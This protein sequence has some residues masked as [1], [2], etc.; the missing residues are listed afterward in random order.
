MKGDIKVI[1]Y[2]K[3]NCP[4][5]AVAKLKLNTANIIYEEC[6]D[7]AKM[8][9]LGIELLPALEKD[10]KIFGFNQIIEMLKGGNN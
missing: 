3:L 1:L 7:E 4:L 2:T 5:C 6:Q 8:E 9:E 10:G